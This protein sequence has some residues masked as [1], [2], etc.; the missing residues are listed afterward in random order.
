MDNNSVVKSLCELEIRS[1][2]EAEVYESYVNAA[3]EDGQTETKSVQR[4]YATVLTVGD[5]RELMESDIQSVS[6][7]TSL[8]KTEATLLLSHFSW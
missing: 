5:I 7:V 3:L 1:E 4:S 2:A 8:S 6:N